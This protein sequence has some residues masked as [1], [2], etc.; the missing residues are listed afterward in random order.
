MGGTPMYK[1][2]SLWYGLNPEYYPELFVTSEPLAVAN[3]HANI[4]NDYTLPG[5]IVRKGIRSGEV[6]WDITPI[7]QKGRRVPFTD[8]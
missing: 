2:G 1:Q 4:V 7:E 8:T 5:R 6:S 3:K